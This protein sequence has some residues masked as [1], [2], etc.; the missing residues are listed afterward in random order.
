MS[1]EAPTR[2]V[3]RRGAAPA[4]RKLFKLDGRS[5]P[6]PRLVVVSV[7][8]TVTE[9]AKW[10]TG[11]SHTETK[12]SQDALGKSPKACAPAFGSGRWSRRSGTTDGAGSL[13]RWQQSF[14]KT[15]RS[16]AQVARR[17]PCGRSWR[18][19]RRRLSGSRTSRTRSGRSGRTSSSLTSAGEPP[20]ADS[21]EVAPP[22]AAGKGVRGLPWSGFPLR[23]QC[24]RFTITCLSSV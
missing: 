23:T 7:R 4:T 12:L 13:S 10:V 3:G 20:E 21:R 14:G 16:L 6:A 19:S 11:T 5:R 18:G 17:S 22:A 15:I 2:G 1:G 24:A 8:A 9:V